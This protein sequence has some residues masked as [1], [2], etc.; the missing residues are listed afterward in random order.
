MMWARKRTTG[1]VEH[2][3]C[4]PY[5]GQLDVWRPV[6]AGWHGAEPKNIKVRKADHDT[7]FVPSPSG[8]QKCL[9]CLKLMHHEANPTDWSVNRPRGRSPWKKETDNG[10]GT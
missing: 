2:F 7:F 1:R 6:C 8:A 10:E 3:W 4:N 9:S 5:Q